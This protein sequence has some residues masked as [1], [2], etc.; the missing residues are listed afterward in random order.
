MAL[1]AYQGGKIDFVALANALQQRNSSQVTYLQQANQF[2]AE[3]I[4][5]EQAIGQP[6]PR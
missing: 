1:V 6:M 3:R 5:L 2:L 4:A